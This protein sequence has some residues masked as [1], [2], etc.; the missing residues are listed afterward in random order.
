MS[1]SPANPVLQTLLGRLSAATKLPREQL[2]GML[3]PPPKA[4]MGDYALPCHAIAGPRKQKPDQAAIDLAAELAL[5]PHLKPIVISIE[6]A[7]AFLNFRLD[8]GA[9]CAAVLP[10]LRA[11]GEAYG[12]SDEGAGQTIVID[13]SSPNIAKPFHVG[14]LMSTVL[15][16]SLARIFRALG[17]PVV[18]VNH[19]GDWGTQCGYQFLAWK[20]A[21]PSEREVQ[22]AARG[23]DYLVDLYVEINRPGKEL[24]SLKDRLLDKNVALQPGERVETEKR[25]AE[26]APVAEEIERKARELFRKLEEGDP[27]LR[28]LWERFRTKTLNVLQLSY[29]RLGVAFESTAG[30]G[31][32][33]PFL[34]P[35]IEDLKQRGILFES[36][37]CWVIPL[38]E[39][40]E[41]KKKP[42]FI[43]VKTDGTTKYDTRDLAAAIYRKTTYDF[44][45]NL[46]VVDVRQ[47]LHFQGLF[48]ALE[49]CG[50]EWAKD[51][52][53]VSYGLMQIKEGDATLP[54]TTRGGRMIP[55]GEL[56]DRMVGIVREIVNEKNPALPPEQKDRVAEAVGVGAIIFWIQA[57]RRSS[58]IVF[59]W[60]E[61]TNPD[62]DTG[63]YVQYTHA[64]ACSILR[65]H[66]TYIPDQPDLTLLR[67]PEEAAVVKALDEFP[68]VLRAAAEG[69]EPSLV[70]TW[71]VS[72]SRS[73]NDFYNKRQ[74]LKAESAAL[75][76]ARLA[77]V[78]AARLGIARGLKLLGVTAPEEM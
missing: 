71:L 23:I 32:Y 45:Q 73:F 34:L 54:M 22:L 33:E 66:G 64:R 5:D 18:G 39:P 58:N 13:Y 38:S 17:H 37:G 52:R 7:G 36:E 60:K 15:G 69:Y 31:F 75:R 56:L 30:E 2:S 70:A 11:A 57:R 6:P 65:K 74:V 12:G 41:K 24:T 48:K 16:A 76:D 8:P 78:D 43:V 3:R 14:H 68:R 49:K 25:I 4:E 19:L 44:A 10:P 29:D 1:A 28:I 20:Q 67:E 47:S 35:L 61:A 51:C 59:D 27:D 46:Y 62:G 9:L 53:H 77:L 50:Y 72:A 21:N 55:L 26:L 63:P 42:P 40:R